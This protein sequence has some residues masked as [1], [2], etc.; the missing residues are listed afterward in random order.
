MGSTIEL[1]IQT[2]GEYEGRSK[3]N[4]PSMEKFDLSAVNFTAGEEEPA[5]TESENIIKE[6]VIQAE[7]VI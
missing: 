6:N 2:S 4:L 5:M 7:E 3:I 1:E